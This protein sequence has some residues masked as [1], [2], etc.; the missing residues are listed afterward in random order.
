MDDR[1]N[2][3]IAEL[4]DGKS[5]SSVAQRSELNKGYL[6]ALWEGYRLGQS[7]RN[8]SRSNNY[9]YVRLF[10][11]FAAGALLEG[12]FLIVLMLLKK[13]GLF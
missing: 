11:F 4:K 9:S 3:A 2:Q 5:I 7:D 6:S 10:C 12:I 1:K 13:R 8:E